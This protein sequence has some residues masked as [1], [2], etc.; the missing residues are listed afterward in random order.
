MLS[1]NCPNPHFF[2]STQEFYEGLGGKAVALWVLIG[3]ANLAQAGQFIFI[4]KRIYPN[5]LVS[6]RESTLWVSTIFLVPSLMSYTSL[7]FPRSTDM[8]WLAYRVYLSLVV[9]HFMNLILDWY[10]GPDGLLEAIGTAE[11]NFRVRPCCCCLW[12]PS[13]A[14]LTRGKAKF[15]AL[16]VKQMPYVHAILTFIIVTLLSSDLLKVGN[17]NPNQ[18]YFYLVLMIFVSFCIGLWGLFVLVRVTTRLKTLDRHRFTIKARIF[19][20][21]IITIN[22]LALI[23]DSLAAYGVIQCAGPLISS[24]TVG[25][26]IKAV[27]TNVFGLT[28]GSVIVY[29]H[30][31]DVDHL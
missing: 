23:V 16:A 24:A 2:P 14:N 30:F 31:N 10:G 26:I 27:I 13:K 4:C 25:S 17:M 1:S 21:L 12:C 29:L 9:V 19:R 6:R 7:I 15:L 11:V 3:L 5:V 22:F 8:V 20:A 18:P 28:L